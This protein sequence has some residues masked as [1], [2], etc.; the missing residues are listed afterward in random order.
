MLRKAGIHSTVLVSPDL[1]HAAVGIAL[2]GPGEV[3]RSRGRS[4]RYVEV[5]HPGW[6][7]GK[8]P[9]GYNKPALWTVT[10]IGPDR[11]L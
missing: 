8:V 1:S 9:P 10:E 11:F 4:C 7:I 6:P 2:P 5:T 3:F